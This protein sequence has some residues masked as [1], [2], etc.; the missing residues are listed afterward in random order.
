MTNEQINDWRYP[1]VPQVI[2]AS[3]NRPQLH[4]LDHICPT[5]KGSRLIESAYKDLLRGIEIENARSIYDCP[6]IAI[7]FRREVDYDNSGSYFNVLGGF[8]DKESAIE[9]ANKHVEDGAAKLLAEPIKSG[10]WSIQ[11]PCGDRPFTLRVET[12][13]IRSCHLRS[14]HVW[15]GS[16][17]DTRTLQVEVVQ[18]EKEA[19][20]IPDLVMFYGDGASVASEW[21]SYLMNKGAE[22]QSERKTC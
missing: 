13:L 16:N 15:N 19:A 17:Y 4:T 10:D 9:F 22:N 3:T 5:W 21:R 12:D 8:L 6:Y 7:E 2:E 1:P 14:V 11:I 20:F 18:M